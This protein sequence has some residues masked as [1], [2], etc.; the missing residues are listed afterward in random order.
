MDYADEIAGAVEEVKASRE[1]ADTELRWLLDDVARA[2]D[3]RVRLS[4]QMKFLAKLPDVEMEHLERCQ[5]PANRF[6]V[7]LIRDGLAKGA[8]E[9]PEDL[10]DEVR[11][12]IE[13]DDEPE[14]NP[15]EGLSF[16]ALPTFEPDVAQRAVNEAAGDA[17]RAGCTCGGMTADPLDTP[18]SMHAKDCP[19]FAEGVRDF[20]GNVG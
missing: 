3:P 8:L 17:E 1:R 5:A 10:P 6:S 9:L 18:P 19:L 20:D 4:A 14:A 13:A 11:A 2:T 12:M 15:L 16:D 7:K